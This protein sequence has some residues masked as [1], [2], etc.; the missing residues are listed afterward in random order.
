MHANNDESVSCLKFEWWAYKSFISQSLLA[1]S[2][3]IQFCT[4]LEGLQHRQQITHTSSV[5]DVKHPQKKR[6]K[7]ILKGCRYRVGDGRGIR[8]MGGVYT[9]KITTSW[10]HCGRLTSRC[11]FSWIT[12]FCKKPL[13][14]KKTKNPFPNSDIINIWFLKVITPVNWATAINLAQRTKTNLYHCLW[15]P[16]II[17][18]LC[19]QPSPYLS[20][21]AFPWLTGQL[22]SY[23]LT[24]T[25]AQEETQWNIPS[26]FPQPHPLLLVQSLYH[27]TWS[28]TVL[29]SNQR[30]V[31]S[32]KYPCNKAMYRQ[33]TKNLS[34][35]VNQ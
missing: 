15:S 21:P 2:Q 35:T 30:T 23:Q 9:H 16:S 26:V 11:L 5:H 10:W 29:Q 13:L 20:T 22:A 6:K 18:S 7:S 17:L 24:S 27:P 1:T 28:W 34:K 3:I 19:N 33:N 31:R 4:Y 12:T 14:L 32:T 8:G 25:G